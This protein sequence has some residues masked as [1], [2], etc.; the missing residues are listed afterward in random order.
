MCLFTMFGPKLKH[1]LA[2][3]KK[4][5]DNA[6][7]FTLDTAALEH[8]TKMKHSSFKYLIYAFK[9]QLKHYEFNK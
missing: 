7:S 9:N 2:F 3:F 6:A 8:V 4:C 5:G 1:E